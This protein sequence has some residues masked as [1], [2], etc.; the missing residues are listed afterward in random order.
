ME[1]RPFLFGTIAYLIPRSD[2]NKLDEI[3]AYKKQE[4]EPLV[5]L[6]KKL[7]ASALMRNEFGGF[8]TALDKGPDQLGVIAE[9]KKAS[10]S[11]GIIDPNFD[12]VRQAKR[13]LDGG[14]SCMSILTDEKYFQGHLSYLVQI[15]KISSIPL[16]R[17]DFTVHECQ[18]YEASVSGADAILLIVAALDDDQLRRLYDAARDIQ[19]D[20]L[21]EVHDLPEMERA[22]DLGADLIGVNNRNL[23][24]FTTDLATTEQLADEVPD[25]VILVSESGLKNSQDAQRALNAGAN[26][27]LIGETLMRH[28]DPTRALEEYLTLRVSE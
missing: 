24:T 21:V 12:P 9:V 18:I 16:L 2:M 5:P 28:D 26:A 20:I 14:A 15:S 1:L 4:I 17:K 3:I 8:R 11:A 22:L 6:T 13:Y 23:K 10:P 25:N 7:R 19:L 27:I